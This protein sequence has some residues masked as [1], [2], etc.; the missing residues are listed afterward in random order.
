MTR[1]DDIRRRDPFY[2]V[3]AAI[4]DGAT[5]SAVHLRVNPSRHHPGTDQN[6]GRE[7]Q[8]RRSNR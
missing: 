1:N 7:N 3:S 6:P 5:I 8:T 2:V 4:G